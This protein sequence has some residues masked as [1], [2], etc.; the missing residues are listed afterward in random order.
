MK[1]W[2]NRMFLCC[3][4]LH[5]MEKLNEL[6]LCGMAVRSIQKSILA[7]RVLI[8]MHLPQ[9]K[10]VHGTALWDLSGFFQPVLSCKFPQLLQNWLVSDQIIS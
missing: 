4:S 9:S 2:S 6:L 7:K 10:L 8:S 1:K 5:Q 3:S